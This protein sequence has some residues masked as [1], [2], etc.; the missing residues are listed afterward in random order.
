[1]SDVLAQPARPRM[2][3]LM[4]P[5]IETADAVHVAAFRAA[6]RTFLRASEEIAQANGLTPR[7]HLLLLMIT[8]GGARDAAQD[9]CRTR[10]QD[11][12]TA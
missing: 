4:E 2:R 11:T 8:R 12:C 6:L 1:M 3:T 10:T 7:R 9:A 5:E